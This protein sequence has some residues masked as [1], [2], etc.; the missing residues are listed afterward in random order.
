VR[1]AQI[2]PLTESVPPRTYG[3]TERVVSVL[4]E[5][6]VARGHK[7]TLFASGDSKT[8]AELVPCSDQ[9][10]RLTDG[11]RDYLALSILEL[12]QVIRRQA[13]F[14]VIHNHLDFLAFPFVGL[15]SAPIL[16]TC[17]GRLDLP[18]TIELY[19]YFN[20][21]P[22]VSI[23]DDQ[24][25]PVPN[26]NWIGTV[27]NGIDF[28]AVEFH[29][30]A[31]DYLAFLGRISPEKRVDRAIEVARE[32]DIPLKI[33]AKID[34]VDQEYFDHAVRPHLNSHNIEFVGEV[35]ESE[36]N[37]FLG[38]ALAYLFPIDWPEPFG[39][40]M[41]ES[42]ACGTPVVALDS[43]SVPE[44]VD[45]GTT[46]FVCSSLREFLDCVSEV[47]RLDRSECRRHAQLRFSGEV[48]TDGYEK[49]YESLVSGSGES[50]QHSLGGSVGSAP[51][52]PPDISVTQRG[53]L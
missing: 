52:S 13:D 20:N 39:L 14:D 17:H 7:V 8:A 48:M 24:R 47:E 21:A 25:R 44:V 1:I 35:N 32:L 43:G 50:R 15:S 41:I 19:S 29:P 34:P 38:G 16:S 37:D 46:G 18:Q 23:S 4:T 6:L 30:A 26:A 36:K 42:M 40:T 9:G 10:L 3:G 28:E 27:P 33:A 5:E 31:G 45:H 2:A 51:A 22:L 53:D 49:A 12:D 11:N